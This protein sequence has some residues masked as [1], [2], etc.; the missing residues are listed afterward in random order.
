MACCW[1]V[2][3]CGCSMWHVSCVDIELCRCVL[4]RYRVASWAIGSLGYSSI[5]G[6]LQGLERCMR[7]AI[8]ERTY[9]QRLEA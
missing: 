7:R 3:A 4:C 8:L 9:K 2:A 5:P 1:H 6:R